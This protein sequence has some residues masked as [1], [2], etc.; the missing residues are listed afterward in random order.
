MLPTYTAGQQPDSSIERHIEST[1][2]YNGVPRSL[3]PLL[4]VTLQQFVDYQRAKQWDKT[5]ELLVDFQFGETRRQKVKYTEDEKSQTVEIIKKQ[6]IEDFKPQ[7]IVFSTE[8]LSSPLSRQEWEILGCAQYELNGQK[9]KGLAQVM[10]YCQNRKWVFGRF[11][12]HTRREDS[13]PAPCEERLYSRQ[14]K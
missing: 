10:A 12:L 2:K 8:N 6:G 3:R 11:M 13:T 7:Q 14:D 9:V 1:L 4:I 5:A